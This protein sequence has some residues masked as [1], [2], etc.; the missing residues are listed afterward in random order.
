MGSATDIRGWV[1]RRS[2]PGSRS[3]CTFTPWDDDHNVDMDGPVPR[4]QVDFVP[5]SIQGL[6]ELPRVLTPRRRVGS[7]GASVD[8]GQFIERRVSMAVTMTPFRPLGPDSASGNQ[9]H[10]YDVALWD[11]SHSARIADWVAYAREV[12]Q[13]GRRGRLTVRTVAPDGAIAERHLDVIVEHSDGGYD[14]AAAGPYHRRFSVGFITDGFPFFYDEEAT[15]EHTL[16]TGTAPEFYPVLPLAVSQATTSRDI[17]LGDGGVI[18]TVTTGAPITDLVLEVAMGSVGDTLEYSEILRLDG[19][20]PPAVINLR[21]RSVVN[22]STEANLYGLV[23][24]SSSWDVF[25][26]AGMENAVLRVSGDIDADTLVVVTYH[27]LTS[28]AYSPTEHTGLTM[29][30]LA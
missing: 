2:W 18:S 25:G 21:D 11:G 26:T 7:H 15:L 8:S 20:L 16:S 3:W 27:R 23:D 12:M 5:D 6:D 1:T 22:S 17:Q 14:P 24:A 4:W 28:V 29:P 19:E 10:F 13:S 30:G 9:A